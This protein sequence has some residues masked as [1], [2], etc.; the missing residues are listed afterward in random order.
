[1]RP[2]SAEHFRMAPPR[3]IRQPLEAM[4]AGFLHTALNRGR[5]FLDKGRILSKKG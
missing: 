2:D 5:P 4:E 1:M 3:K